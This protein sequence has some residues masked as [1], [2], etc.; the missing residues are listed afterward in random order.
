M[1]NEWIGILGIVIMGTAL[2]AFSLAKI[3][4]YEDDD[5]IQEMELRKKTDRKEKDQ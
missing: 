5:D 2:F 4:D 1:E 3:S